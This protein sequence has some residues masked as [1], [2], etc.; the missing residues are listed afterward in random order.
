MTRDFG[1]GGAGFERAQACRSFRVA[2]NGD[3]DRPLAGEAAHRGGAHLFPGLP[4][5][6]GALGVEGR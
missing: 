6:C 3:V 2:L 1:L 4:Q 5:G